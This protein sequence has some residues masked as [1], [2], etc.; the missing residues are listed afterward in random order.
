MKWRVYCAAIV[1]AVPCLAQ[2]PPSPGQQVALGGPRFLQSAAPGAAPIDP[3]SVPVLQ[4]RVTLSAE[5]STLGAALQAITTQTGVRFLLSRDVVPVMARVR[6][7][8]TG[9]SL[10][11]ALTELLLHT[12]VDVAV[13]S[14]KE[15]ALVRRGMGLRL[16]GGTIV[17]RVTDTAGAA[18]A[19]VEMY[20]DGTQWR[21]RTDT[22]G[23]YRLADAD[24]GAYTLV[25]RRLGYA[26]GS[27]PVTV[28]D[29][30]TDTVNIVLT[31]VVA[32]L[33]ELVTTATGQRRRL[34]IAN[35]ITTINADSVMQAAPIRNV[36]DLLEGRVPGLTVQRT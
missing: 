23:W 17:G 6:V 2:E 12:D 7:N 13:V 18:V 4:R 3:R 31:P 22:A 25:A 15:L 32:R 14:S 10:A 24:A 1:F 19:G 36:T 27:R 29:G 5:Q 11:A 28:R 21:T 20:L 8:A 30:Q 9:L 16:P 33:Q 34:D 26:K 35:D